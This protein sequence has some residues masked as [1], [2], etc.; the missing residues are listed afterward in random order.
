MSNTIYVGVTRQIAL[1]DEMRTIAANVANS[2]TPGYRREGLIFSEYVK[3][4][5]DALNSLSMAAARAR[6]ANTEQGE[7]VPTG[8]SFDLAIEGDGYFQVQTP[9]GV[10]LTR[11]GAFK[12]SVENTLVTSD[13]HPVLGDGGAPLFVPA[14]AAQI[15][16]ARDGTLSADGEPIGRVGLV[17]GDPLKMTR[18]AGMLYV[19]GDDI[20]PVDNP[21]ISQGFLED[22]NVNPIIEI[23]RMIEVQRGYEAG[24][25][26]MRDEDERIRS[27][28]QVMGGQ[29]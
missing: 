20:V 27:A 10:R 19:P 26:L 12:P 1:L 11:A 3:P 25:S 21:H 29:N 7:L 5:D 22:S 13:G 6:Y 14:E 15:K 24:Q 17:T 18:E 16:I 8:G 9:N 23:A 4:T 28:L 2:S